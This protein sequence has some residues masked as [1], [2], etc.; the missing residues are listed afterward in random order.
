MYG[1]DAQESTAALRGNR[2]L[3]RRLV[4]RGVR[5]VQLMHRGW[6]QRRHREPLDPHQ[7]GAMLAIVDDVGALERF[8]LLGALV[9]V[10]RQPQREER[11]DDR[12]FARRAPWPA[13][14]NAMPKLSQS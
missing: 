10:D 2:L 1:I 4:E 6:D 8:E 5:F 13:S 11:V 7:R 3:A 12:L 14:L 9:L